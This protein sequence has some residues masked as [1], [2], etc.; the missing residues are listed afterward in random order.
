MSH[1]QNK[2]ALATATQSGQP[3][4]TG[5]NPPPADPRV[6]HPAKTTGLNTRAT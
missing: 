4:Q 5:F 1:Q 3:Y 6:A 2:P